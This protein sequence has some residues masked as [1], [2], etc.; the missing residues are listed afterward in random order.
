MIIRVFRLGGKDPEERPYRIYQGECYVTDP[1]EGNSFYI[2]HRVAGE[3][4]LVARF[5]KSEFGFFE[6][7]I[8]SKQASLIGSNTKV[9]TLE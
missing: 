7:S 5:S 8:E 4:Q 9:L 2:S 3:S 1:K 6:T